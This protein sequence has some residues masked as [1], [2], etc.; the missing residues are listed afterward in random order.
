[1][2]GTLPKPCIK[3]QKEIEGCTVAQ[4]WT[5]TIILLPAQL[6]KEEKSPGHARLADRPELGRANGK[7]RK[8][9]FNGHLSV[10]WRI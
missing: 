6:P 5:Q 9:N 1:V 2:S 8:K 4:G 7:E 10:Q 3:S